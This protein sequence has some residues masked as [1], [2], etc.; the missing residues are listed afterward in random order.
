MMMMR[1]GDDTYDCHGADADIEDDVES[2]A[3]GGSQS[4]CST[5]QFSSSMAIMFYYLSRPGILPI[6]PNPKA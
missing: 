2:I 4:P 5:V 1:R 6:A 3:E